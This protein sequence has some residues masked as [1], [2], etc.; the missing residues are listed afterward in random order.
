MEKRLA[1]HDRPRSG[2]APRQPHRLV[3]V[4]PVLG[5]IRAL[6]S[7]PQRIE[8]RVAA[9]ECL[10]D[11]VEERRVTSP[12]EVVRL[13]S[14]TSANRMRWRGESRASAARAFCS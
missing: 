3:V 8:I 11:V 9:E 10:L 6:D 13:V 14:T 2:S 7:L 5:G 12:G 1:D 4:D